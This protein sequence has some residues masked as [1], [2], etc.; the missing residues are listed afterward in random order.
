MQTLKGIMLTYIT[1]MESFLQPDIS[2]EKM[3]NQSLA[4]LA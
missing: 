4:C 2:L 1:D 3:V